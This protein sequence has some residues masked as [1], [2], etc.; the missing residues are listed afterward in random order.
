MGK[1]RTVIC[2]L[3]NDL[4][5][6]D[7]EVVPT[8][9]G[10]FQKSP[11]NYLTLNMCRCCSG[12]TGMGTTSFLS[13]ALTHSTLKA[14]GTSTSPKQVKICAIVKSFHVLLLPAPELLLI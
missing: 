8:F 5:I 3:R 7:N 4:R 11:E 12:L 2:L 1:M 9:S 10:T 14:R 6:H 13:S